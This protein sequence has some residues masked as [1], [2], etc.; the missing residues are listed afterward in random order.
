[1]IAQHLERQRVAPGV[2]RPRARPVGD[3]ARLL[4]EGWPGSRDRPD[5]AGIAICI[6]QRRLQM[7]GSAPFVRISPALA[8]ASARP[9]AFVRFP[10][11]IAAESSQKDAE[12]NSRDLCGRGRTVWRAHR[13]AGAPRPDLWRPHRGPCAPS[14]RPGRPDHNISPR[15]YRDR[16]WPSRCSTTSR[17]PPG[18]GSRRA[19]VAHRCPGAGLAVYRG[20]RP[21]PPARTNRIGQD[22]RRVPRRHRPPGHRRDPGQGQAVPLLYISPLRALA[23]D[24]EKNLRSPLAGITLRPPSAWGRRSPRPP[25]ACAPATRPRRVRQQSPGTPPDI[26]IT[27]PES[28]YLMLTSQAGEILRSVETVIVDE[29]HARPH[30][31]RRTPDVVARAARGALPTRPAGN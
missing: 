2:G 30:Q 28:L 3:P 6:T 27:T 4:R 16:P 21:H 12:T 18:P 22:A 8:V 31:A 29:I 20:R 11:A 19:S 15:P 10:T 26:L 13:L 1:M 24:I 5:G 25:S 17:R 14:D 23:V 9:A 7:Q